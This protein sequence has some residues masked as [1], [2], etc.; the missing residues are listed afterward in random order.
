MIEQQVKEIVSRIFKIEMSQIQSDFSQENINDWDSL[1]HLNLVVALEKKFAI[2]IE[3]DEIAI[4]YD[5]KSI[6]NL[7]NA[8]I[9][10]K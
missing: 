2:Q 7:I 5:L 9:K 3:P 4:M 1:K 10:L 6:I 8:K